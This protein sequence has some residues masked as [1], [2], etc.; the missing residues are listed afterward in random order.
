M[1]KKVLALLLSATVMAG[2]LSGCGGIKASGGSGASTA[3]GKSESTE[4]T[5]EVEEITMLISGGTWTPGVQAVVE[6]A[7]EEIGIR[8]V[9]E[10]RPGGPEGDNLIRTRLATGDGADIIQANS[11][12]LLAAFNPHEYF[13]DLSKEGFKEVLDPMFIDGASVGDEL[14]GIPA[15]PFFAGGVVYNR[16][17]YE[18]YN[19]EI[20]D[21]WEE[22]MENIRI[23]DEAGETAVLG[24]YA[25]SGA[26]QILWIADTYNLL[27]E[28]PDFP[29]EFEAGRAKWATT[30]AALRGFEKLAEVN[31]YLNAD[32]L[33]TTVEEGYSIMANGE[34]GHWFALSLWLTDAAAI[35]GFEQVDNLGMF[36]VPADAATGI[37]RGMTMWV[38]T[39]FYA[40]QASDNID[41]VLRFFEFYV[42]ERGQ[43]IF[44]ANQ[45]AAG[46]S[47]VVGVE[48]PENS[49]YAVSTQ[50]Q[51]YLDTG[52]TSPALEF[53]TPLKGP[54]A[55]NIT[56]A[57]GAGQITPL[58]GA[59]QYDE[60]NAQQA[61]QL[62]L[63]W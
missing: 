19:L 3:G 24:T 21:T 10:T 30:P 6:A 52:R 32:P 39:A 17:M 14:F 49:L 35:H 58:E 38:P 7:E 42:S 53:L 25:G 28:E 1:K 55:P 13:V 23:L 45:L 12:G 11:G 9:V 36:G 16:E 37:E 4:G 43:E 54:N 5:G 44:F 34:A 27:Q 33:A 41:A 56:Q 8:V 46:P 26:T 57:I 59:T 18:K 51:G 40:N 63:D 15:T 22:L 29:A 48:L 50:I 2:L 20:P 60:D 61:R 62:G 47:A 31:P